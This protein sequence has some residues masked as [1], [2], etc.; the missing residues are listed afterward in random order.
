VPIDREKYMEAYQ[1]WKDHATV[2]WLGFMENEL[3]PWQD[4]LK[5]F[6]SSKHDGFVWVIAHLRTKVNLEIV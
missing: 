4:L 3:I 2:A 6:V 5:M 1:Y